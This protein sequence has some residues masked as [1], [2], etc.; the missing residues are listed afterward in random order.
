[1]SSVSDN[2]RTILS[3]LNM[4]QID[5]AKSVGASFG[6]INMVINSRRTSISRQFALL[7]EEKYGYSADWI[8]HN[9]GDKKTSPFKN[10]K[11]YKEM[12]TQ[13]NQLSSEEMNHLFKYILFLEKKEKNEKE[14]RDLKKQIGRFA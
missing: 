1:M 4:S 11:G 6:Y 8:L 9:E 7:I 10:Q 14:K 3:E 12:K 5:F 2:L 13:I